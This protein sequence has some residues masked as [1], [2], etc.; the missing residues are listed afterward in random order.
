MKE[1]IKKSFLWGVFVACVSMLMSM[2]AT[3]AYSMDGDLTDW[4]ITCADLTQGLG[5]DNASWLPN[6]GIQFVVE[7]NFNPKEGGT[8]TGVHIKGVGSS[9]TF[10]DEPKV[11]FKNTSSMVW[12][13]Y[14]GEHYDIE[15]MY[16][17]EDADYIY[18]AVVTS[19]APAAQG[20]N[21]PGDLALNLDG[22]CPH[23]DNLTECYE[24]GVKLGTKTGL[25]QWDIYHDPIWQTPLYIPENKPNNFNGGGN[26]TGNATGVYSNSWCSVMDHGVMNYIIEMKIAKSDVENPSDVR[27]GNLHLADKCG[28]DHVP[29]APEPIV[30]IAAIS[31][32]AP[33]LGYG[34]VRRRQNKN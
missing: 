33:A 5:G 2:Q 14:G 23:K 11:Q 8:Y 26:K 29:P 10:Y 15:A 4:G 13:P 1:M 25:S 34:L 19:L 28:N 12:E 16:F 27:F 31:A 32:L 20:D 6:A 18:I 21:A 9:Y 17:D 3:A 24:Y 30:I 7:D 22:Y